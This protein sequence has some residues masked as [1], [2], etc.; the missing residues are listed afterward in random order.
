[1]LEH[2]LDR[3]SA[4]ADGVRRV[5]LDLRELEFMDSSG[6]RLVVLAERALARPAARFA[7]VRGTDDVQRVFE[8]TRM[9][10]RLDVRGRSGR[11]RRR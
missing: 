6:L 10:D 1:M 7:L 5:V 4:E 9:R 8:I 11:G 3:L 2:E